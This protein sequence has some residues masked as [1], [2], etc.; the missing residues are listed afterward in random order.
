MET[1]RNYVFN[2]FSSFP[3]SNKLDK[4]KE[5]ILDTMEDKY[6]EL[7]KQGKS[8]NES[9]GIVISEFGNIDELISELDI[10]VN[11]EN[12]EFPTLN[13]EDVKEFL[14]IKKKTTLFISIG[15]ALCMV[16]VSLLISVYQLIEDKVILPN[17]PLRVTEIVPLIPLF[18]LL[19]PA[20]GLFIYSGFQ[21]EKY[22]YVE[23]GE[24]DITLDAK[25]YLENSLSLF[26][27]KFTFGCIIGVSLCVISPLILF[28][29]SAISEGTAVY[30]TSLIIL[31]VAI[32]VFIFTHIGTHKSDLQALLKI[33][34][35]SPKKREENK[36][37]AAVASVVWPLTVCIYLVTSFVFGNWQIS[38]VIFP[39]VGILFGAFSA[40]CSIIK[41]DSNKIS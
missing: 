39:V 26:K 33:G 37:V 22:K 25:Y 23:K 28:I 32:A 41:G 11:N 35:F 27:P 31:I 1:I 8:E 40:V 14:N 29:G 38:W 3:K 20:I 21:R 15:V 12:S 5:D 10:E 34:D 18:I 4:L 9:I 17:V 24:F 2:I 19:V 13:T 30:C 6:N 36:V 16:G 7:K